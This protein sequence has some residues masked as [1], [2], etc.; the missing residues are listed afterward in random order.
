MIWSWHRTKLVMALH[1]KAKF[2]INAEKFALFERNLLS[3]DDYLLSPCWWTFS[4]EFV[5]LILSNKITI[6]S[7]CSVS[8]FYTRN[9]LYHYTTWVHVHKDIFFF[10]KGIHNEDIM[11]FIFEKRYQTHLIFCFKLWL[12]FYH[13]A[14][15]KWEVFWRRYFLSKTFEFSRQSLFCIHNEISFYNLSL[16]K[17]N[18]IVFKLINEMKKKEFW[19]KN[20]ICTNVSF[21]SSLFELF[22]I[23]GILF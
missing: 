4:F 7:K 16:A 1:P 19:I 23:N 17:K 20:I 15:W 10:L 9:L 5:F 22:K 8:S 11:W 14:C 18:S 13:Y 3:I 2:R 12:F 6:I 21:V